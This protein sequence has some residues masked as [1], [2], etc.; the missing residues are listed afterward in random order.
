LRFPVA[1]FRAGDRLHGPQRPNSERFVAM[2]KILIVDDHPLFREALRGAVEQG[3]EVASVLEASTI[4]ETVTLIDQNDDIDLV[5]LDLD[6]PGTSGF[7]GLLT[8]RTRFPKQ[9]IV[10]ISG[11]HDRRIIDEALSYGVAG[12]IPKSVG[13]STLHS[14]IQETLA[15]GLYLPPNYQ[16]IAGEDGSGDSDLAKRL[17]SLTPQQFR[18]LK[19]LSEGKLNKQI[20]YEL[21]VGETTV[22]AHV[23]AILRKLNVYSRTQAVIKARMMEFDNILSADEE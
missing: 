11:S 23:S 12:F 3:L 19:M 4:D 20:A 15:G 2:T 5:L 13:K 17:A 1:A 9:P 18:V 21:N 22:K 7:A 14:A 16:R 8:L 6:L 10:I